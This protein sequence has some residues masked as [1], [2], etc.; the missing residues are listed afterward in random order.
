MHDQNFVA[1]LGSIQYEDHN[2]G[3]LRTQFIEGD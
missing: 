2:I 1:A 3:L